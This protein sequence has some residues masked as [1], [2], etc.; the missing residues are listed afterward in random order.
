MDPFYSPKASPIVEGVPLRYSVGFYRGR[1]RIVIGWFRDFDN[2]MDF[3]KR[4]RR[5][6]P[7][8]KYDL[9]KSIF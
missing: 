2:A 5:N 1:C 6:N 8:F 4:S 3:L 9:C 7:R